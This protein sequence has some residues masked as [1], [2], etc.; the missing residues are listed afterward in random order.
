MNL[1]D[2]AQKNGLTFK[3]AGG[4]H[5]GKYHGPCPVCGGT[6]RFHIWPEQGDHGT[7]WCRSCQLAGDAIEYLIK[8]EGLSFPAACKELGKTL[9]EKE[10]YQAPHFKRPAAATQAFTPR[11]T[12][13]AS[14]LWVKHATKLVDWAHEQLLDNQ[15]QLAWL[16]ARGLDLEAVKRY[17]LGWN[18][19]EKGKDLYRAREAWGLETVLKDD[20]KAKKLWIPLGMIIP[21]YVGDLLQRVRIRRPEGEPRYYLVPG[22]N[23][24]P[25]ILATPQPPPCISEGGGAAAPLLPVRRGGGAV[26]IVESE[27][28]ALLIH[29]LAGDLVG[30]ISPG[31]STAKPDAAASY[32]LTSALVI[33]VALDSDHAGM[34]ASAWWQQHFPQSERWPV[35]VGKDPGDAYKAGVDI[36]AWVKAGLPP[37]MTLPPA[38]K[39]MAKPASSPVS[40]DNISGAVI[41]A[42]ASEPE[43]AAVVVMRTAKDGRTFHITN[44]ATAYARLVAAGEV[45]FDHAE[46]ALAVKSGATPEEA[47]HFLTAKQHFPGIRIDAV[48]PWAEPATNQR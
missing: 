33:L 31:N 7:F 29:H 38:A 13:A 44:D 24:A 43:M 34:Q 17:R 20:G 18:P 40:Q 30:A 37:V 32:V 41:S 22:S 8:I 11:E 36:R 3:R 47:A 16:A 42:A 4:L 48:L 9:P 15:E 1:L 12:S 35:P 39:P 19:G 14:D 10:E 26:V 2:I 46:I 45:V 6:D 23:M 25:M 5:G 28:D 21:Y 27:L